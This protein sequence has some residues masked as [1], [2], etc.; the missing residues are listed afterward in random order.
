MT[1]TLSL[2]SG[3][4]IPDGIDQI[5]SVDDRAAFLIEQ[6]GGAGA[7]AGPAVEKEEP[8]PVAAKTKEEPQAAAA[9]QPA[10]A[11]VEAVAAETV[12][13]IIAEEA[14]PAGESRADKFAR[15]RRQEREK[16]E[17]SIREKT[18]AARTA[19][20]ERIASSL[21]QERKLIEPLLRIAKN[22]DAMAL[23]EF[24]TEHFQP[25]EI[26]AAYSTW[27]SDEAREKWRTRSIKNDALAEANAKIE[28]LKKYIETTIVAP[29][30]KAKQEAEHRAVYD[31]F[32]SFVKSNK[33]YSPATAALLDK[34]P[35]WL[36]AQADTAAMLLGRRGPFTWHDVVSYLE[37]QLPQPAAPQSTG[38]STPP[39]ATAK[40]TTVTN[41]HA[42]ERTTV[43]EADE[44]TEEE[45]LDDRAARLTREFSGRSIQF[46]R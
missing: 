36:F 39:N 45:S 23:H 11:D 12:K 37:Q 25:D 41:R 4:N 18:E 32:A 14:K 30:Q 7:L 33:E 31:N 6:L 42:A 46:H 29:Q 34:N 1:A 19:E 15:I 44:P 5:D 24:V 17:R 43:E 2:D 22:K 3:D 27:T 35:E 40:A 8:A 26:G 20:L 28:E 9:E 13:E 21:D 38:P 16:L 10:K